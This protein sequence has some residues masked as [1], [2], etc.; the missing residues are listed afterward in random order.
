ML[1]MIISRA[2]VVIRVSND[3][4]FVSFDDEEDE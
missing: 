4:D 1:I 2:P 3:D